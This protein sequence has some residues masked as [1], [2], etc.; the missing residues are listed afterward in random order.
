MDFFS[1]I[2]WLTQEPSQGQAHTLTTDSKACWKVYWPSLLTEN[3]HFILYVDGLHSAVNQTLGIVRRAVAKTVNPF[4]L[5]PSLVAWLTAA[6]LWITAVYFLVRMPK[7]EPQH[8]RE[9]T[10]DA[11]SDARSD[12][13]MTPLGTT[14]DGENGPD[15][16]QAGNCALEAKRAIP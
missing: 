7:T 12:A 15:R 4:A 2:L 1:E 6:F 16:Q 5:S 9:T 13:S 14:N 11:R 8:A 10:S 3:L